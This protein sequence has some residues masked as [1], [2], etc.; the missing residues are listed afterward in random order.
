MDRTG[1]IIGRMTEVFGADIRRINHALKVYGFA[2]AIGGGEGFDAGLME[3]LRYAAVLH[4]VGIAVSEKKYGSSA[5]RYQEL[6]G[7]PVARAILESE[8]V[9]PA[10]TER[11]CFLIGHHHTYADIDGPDYQALVEADFL[12]NAFEDALSPDAIRS[13]KTKLFRTAAGSAL[14]S[15]LY[16]V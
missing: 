7:P 10:M 6:E 2:V 3:G 16:G 15:R 1:K 9:D 13:V 11:I 14:L 4:D 12:V 5:G 8:G